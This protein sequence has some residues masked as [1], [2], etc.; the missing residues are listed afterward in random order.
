M[1]WLSIVSL[2][3]GI[4]VLVMQVGILIQVWRSYRRS[5]TLINYWQGAFDALKARVEELE[6]QC[7]K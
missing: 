1:R 7:I 4:A 5:L 6:A 2:V 3:M